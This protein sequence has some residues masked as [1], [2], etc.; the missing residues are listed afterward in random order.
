MTTTARA[1][2]TT[3]VRRQLGRRLRRL[4]EEAGKT[5]DDLQEAKIASR[6]T[7]WRIEGGKTQVEPGK[8]FELCRFYGAGYEEID[9]LAT[10]AEGTK[11]GGFFEAFGKAV[12][13][14]FNLY[15]DLESSASAVNIWHPELVPGLLQTESYARA[16]IGYHPFDAD[17]LESR[18]AFRKERQ[19]LVLNGEPPPQ[20]TAVLGAGA[21]MLVVGSEAV[22]EEQRD[23]LRSL[24]QRSTVDITV[25][26]WS[27]GPHPSTKGAFTLLDYDDPDDPA[28][29]FVEGHHGD[30]YLDEPKDV[31]EYRRVF[32]VVHGL[33]RPIEEYR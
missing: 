31:A 29:V 5:H 19:R 32:D 13:D 23:H 10:L 17:E 8:V 12:P 20:V 25:L 24:G 9:T 27:A 11:G 22:M 15:A 1:P 14:G 28:M 33:A 16:L 3:V 26:P 4:R 6:T 30:S 2:G 18:V 7:M 21:L